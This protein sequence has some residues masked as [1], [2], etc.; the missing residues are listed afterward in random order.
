[1]NIVCFG[2]HPDDAEWYAGGTLVKWVR[3]GHRVLSVA[4][5]N[6]DIGHHEMSGGALAQRRA[7][8]SRR[9]AERAGTIS[10]VL[11][12]HDGELYPSLAL[13]KEIVRIIR[14]HKA[15]VVLTHRPCD[16]HP[17]HRYS[18][19]AVQDAAFMVTVPFF[20]PDTPVLRK[21]P[22]FLYMMD[23]FTKPTPFQPDIAVDVSDVMDVKWS[24][25]DAMES[26]MYEWLPWLDGKHHLVPLDPAARLIWLKDAWGAFFRAPAESARLALERWYGD[27]AAGV[28]YAELFEI[29]EYGRVPTPSEIL[30]LFPFLPRASA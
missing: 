29:C 23:Q 17:D 7:A 5:T 11:D 14:N 30:D 15:D 4:L 18:A 16:Y 25:L 6:G 28:T 12:N 20:C 10:L 24:M 1:M 2:A 9:C 22:L 21:N 13:R 19:I 3:A 27:A 26:Q 8:E